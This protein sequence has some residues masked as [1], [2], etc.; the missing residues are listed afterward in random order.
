MKILAI[1]AGS[2][3]AGLALAD[4]RIKIALPYKVLEIK[5]QDVLFEELKEIVKQEKIEKIVVGQPIGLS[6][7][8]TKQTEI[9]NQFIK[10]VKEQIKLPVIVIDERLTSKM[11]EATTKY[12]KF[13]K[14]RKNDIHAVAASIIL[15]NYLDKKV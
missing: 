10:E 8:Q 7:R 2:R 13:T 9:I 11:A 6:G 3:Y 15:Q 4:D 5:N 1:D 14:V 12:E